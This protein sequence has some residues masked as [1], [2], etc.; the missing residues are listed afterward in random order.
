MARATVPGERLYIVGNISEFGNGDPSRGVEM[1]A[2]SY[3]STYPRWEATV[4]IN[5]PTVLGYRYYQV[6]ANGAGAYENGDNREF[7]V[8]T[9]TCLRSKE[10]TD[11]WRT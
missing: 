4:E 8:Q 10:V 5:V 3:Q 6:E 1:N 7:S 2:D 11:T 9:G